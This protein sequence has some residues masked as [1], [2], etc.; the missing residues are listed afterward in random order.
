MKRVFVTFLLTVLVIAML[1]AVYGC[2]TAD[3]DAGP[4]NGDDIPVD[5]GTPDG[6]QIEDETSNQP[7]LGND[8]ENDAEDEQQ[9]DDEFA[10]IAR[11]E[12]I[13]MGVLV[14]PI[15]D[16]LGEPMH[17]FEVPSCAFD[18]NDR[19]WFYSG[20][21]LHAFPDGDEHFVL[22]VVLNDDSNGT[23]NGVFIG[24]TYE[25]MVAV[26]GDGYEQNIDQFKYIRGGTSLAFIISDGFIT[27]ITYRFEDAPEVEM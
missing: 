2:E 24:M 18:G 6:P 5:M 13:K 27:S 23:E 22:S 4:G 12:L 1:F 26:Y 9:Y 14:D 21:E 17:F 20:F 3:V 7:D 19:V 25:Q 11:G 10:I 8:L 16:N 15:V